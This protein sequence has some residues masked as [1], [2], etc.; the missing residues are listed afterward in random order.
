MTPRSDVSWMRGWMSMHLHGDLNLP[1]LQ[2]SIW[3]LR[4]GMSKSWMNCWSVV[5][6]LMLEQKEPVA[7]SLHFH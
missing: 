3:L 6:I 4:V 7:V 1:V 2:H 5:Q